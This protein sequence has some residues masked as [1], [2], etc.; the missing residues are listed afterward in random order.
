MVA[1]LIPMKVNHQLAKRNLQRKKS[2]LTMV[3]IFFYS[4]FLSFF[5]SD[6]YLLR[7]HVHG[8]NYHL[9]TNRFKMWPNFVWKLVFSHTVWWQ[10]LKC[11]H[12]L[13][14]MVVTV[15]SE[16][17]FALQSQF[18]I[19][20]CKIIDRGELV[21]CWLKFL[22]LVMW[23]YVWFDMIKLSTWIPVWILKRFT[24]SNELEYIN[25]YNI[26]VL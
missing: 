14:V 4:F 7:F 26:T 11:M 2:L 12:T 13:V 3:W 1:I 21:Y 10:K 9:G 16:G 19:W 23:C 24:W 8:I 5:L 25:N 15:S 20:I 22:L 18:R 6:L 17:F